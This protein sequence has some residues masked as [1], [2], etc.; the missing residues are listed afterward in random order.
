MAAQ[1]KG[2]RTRKPSELTP[3]LLM[4]HKRKVKTDCFLTENLK[5]H[6][7]A[8][9]TKIQ[10]R[11]GTMHV[12]SIVDSAVL[13]ELIVSDPNGTNPIELPKAYTTNGIPV[14]HEQ[15]PTRKIIS[16]IDHLKETAG[17][18][19]LY[20]QEL[21]IRLLIGSN[22]PTALVPL[23]VVPNEGDGLFTVR[24]HHG[25]TVRGQLHFVTTPTM[26]KVTANRITVREIENVE[27][28]STPQSLLQLFELDFNEM[29][30]TSFPEDLSYSQEG[31]RFLA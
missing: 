13:E 6:L 9:S 4:F 29:A 26:N 24:L 18:I 30:S 25:W 31:R 22:C 3:C 2:T 8:A 27:E 23:K 14:Q 28:I 17:E 21:D 1:K 19:P 12:Q 7:E 20:N 15:I 11:L 10:L 16:R 5:N